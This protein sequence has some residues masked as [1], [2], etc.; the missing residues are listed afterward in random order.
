[1]ENK[2][3]GLKLQQNEVPIDIT[4]LILNRELIYA[5]TMY[6]S[7]PSY[8]SK[9]QNSVPFDVS[10]NQTNDIFLTPKTN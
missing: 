7:S 9:L 6:P 8:I 2:I 3:E 4:K 1:M 10:L 5:S